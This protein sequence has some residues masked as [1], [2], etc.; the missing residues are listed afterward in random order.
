MVNVKQKKLFSKEPITYDD[1]CVTKTVTTALYLD[2]NEN[3]G[4]DEHNYIFI[5]K[6]GLFC[7]VVEGAGGGWLVREKEGKYYSAAGAK[8]YRW[9]EAETVKGLG[10]EDKID[11]RYFDRLVDEA[12]TDISEYGDFERFTQ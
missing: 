7:P 8:G 9:S 5:G 12:V 11:M 1:L 10:M 6:A 2:C 4:E 3:L